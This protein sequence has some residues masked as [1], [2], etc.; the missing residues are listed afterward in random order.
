VAKV[1]D[2]GVAKAPGQGLTGETPFTGIAR[3][4][5]T[6]PDMSTRVGVAFDY[7]TTADA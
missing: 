6:P 3:M 2:F 4:I 1:A 7:R 5:G